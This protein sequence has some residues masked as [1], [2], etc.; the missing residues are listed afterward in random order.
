MDGY[1]SK[2]FHKSQLQAQ[3]TKFIPKC[4]KTFDS[5]RLDL[6]QGYEDELGQDLRKALV[7]SYLKT[8]TQ[9]FL[10]LAEYQERNH[11]AFQRLA[12]SLKSSTASVGGSLLAE[13]FEEL[14]MINP[15]DL[16]Q[17]NKLKD[18]L[19]EFES[20]KVQLES[21]ISSLHELNIIE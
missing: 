11:E 4:K 15:T 21:Y 3:L 20:L 17:S 1:I 18:A 14:E 10:D 9:S 19:D 2:P 8:A 5:A 13:I 6:F 16:L 12:H 7:E